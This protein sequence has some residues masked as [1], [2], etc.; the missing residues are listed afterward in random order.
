MPS[1]P[2]R[3]DSGSQSDLALFTAAQG[4]SSKAAEELRSRHNHALRAVAVGYR[5]DLVSIDMLV[6][7]AFDNLSDVGPVTSDGAVVLAL[8]SLLRE[9]ASQLSG[10]ASRSQ[11]RGLVDLTVY[12]QTRQ[13]DAARRDQLL[14]AFESL[15]ARDQALLWFAT[16][17]GMLPSA[18]AGRI[19]I[20]ST[21]MAATS[22]HR[23]RSRLRAVYGNLRCASPELPTTCRTIGRNLASLSDGSLHGRAINEATTHHVETCDTCRELLGELDEINGLLLSAGA[24]LVRSAGDVLTLDGAATPAATASTSTRHL[25][26]LAGVFGTQAYERPAWRRPAT[27]VAGAL[28][29]IVIVGLVA[30][31][32]TR[33][34]SNT[35]ASQHAVVAGPVDHRSTTVPLHHGIAAINSA[36]STSAPSLTHATTSAVGTAS[37]TTNTSGKSL[38]DT[39]GS[40]SLTGPGPS[41]SGSPGTTQRNSGSTTTIPTAGTTTTSAPPSSADLAV[42]ISLGI[43]PFPLAAT[44][45]N[46]GP[47]TATATTLTITF[48]DPS[49]SVDTSS[50]PAGSSCS[51]SPDNPL[52]TSCALGA[53][54][55]GTPWTIQVNPGTGSVTVVVSSSAGDPDPSNNTTTWPLPSN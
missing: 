37:S 39:S 25:G 15:G 47:Q 50:V 30:F 9:A 4:G 31:G 1:E 45:T 14:R 21:D 51:V 32:L 38:T 7:R 43:G 5:T 22:A 6:E 23:A 11:L 28:A 33:G 44:V 17:E 13:S 40:K 24:P 8:F 49:G 46:N 20:G 34:S 52:V 3:P 29:A 26:V 12:G 53:V 10:G 55:S 54:A 35:Q 27:L 16:F 48:T 42:S 18:L 36:T 41:G 19:P 2:D